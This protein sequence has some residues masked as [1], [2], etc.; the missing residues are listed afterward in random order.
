[1][2]AVEDAPARGAGLRGHLLPFPL[3]VRPSVGASLCRHLPLPVALAVGPD[4]QQA[5]PRTRGAQ[6]AQC[7]VPRAG[8][9]HL[10]SDAA[11]HLSAWGAAAGTCCYARPRVCPPSAR[12]FVFQGAVMDFGAKDDVLGSGD[13]GEDVD[14]QALAQVWMQ[15]LAAAPA[16]AEP[17]AIHI[18]TE[19]Q[20]GLLKYY[21]DAVL[22]VSGKD[23]PG[24]G[25]VAGHGD[26]AV[27]PDALPD[28][29]HD[30]KDNAGNGGG[31]LPADDVPLHMA[32]QYEQ[33][34]A[35]D[36][37]VLL[38]R[39]RRPAQG[40]LLRHLMLNQ[41]LSDLGIAS[42]ASVEL[43]SLHVTR[44]ASVRRGEALVVLHGFKAIIVWASKGGGDLC[45]FCSCG[46][47]RRSTCV[48]TLVK[49]RR[50]STCPHAAALRCAFSDLAL[51]LSLSSLGQLVERFPGLL[52]MASADDENPAVEHVTALRNDRAVWSV[53]AMGVWCTL[54]QPIKSASSQV[55]RCQNV[56]CSSRMRCVHVLAYMQHKADNVRPEDEDEGQYDADGV[57]LER[58]AAGTE[59]GGLPPVEV[60]EEQSTS[61]RSRNMLPCRG[62]V[63]SCTIFDSYGRAGRDSLS[64]MGSLPGV[65][66]ERSCVKCS[67]LRENRPLT[68]TE[69]VLFTMGGRVAVR[70]GVWTCSCTQVVRYDGADSSL[71]AFSSKT[72][73][74]RMYLD[75]VLHIALTSRSSFTAA[76]AA[77]AF[78]LHVTAGLPLAVFGQTR[79]IIIQA[80]GAYTETLIIPP[81]TYSCPRCL[82]KSGER[83]YVTMIADGQV[84]GFFREMARP[85]VRHLIDNPVVD[86]LI[87]NGCSVKTA[88]V[89]SAI[90][91]RC[92]TP[93]GKA[94]S[95]NAAEVKALN[96][97]L[98]L[99]SRVPGSERKCDDTEI[100]QSSAAEAAWAASYI[101]SSFFKIKNI[102][103][104]NA[105]S[106]DSELSDDVQA[107]M[108]SSSPVD[109]NTAVSSGAGS[110]SSDQ[111]PAPTKS[112]TAQPS[113]TAT[114][115]H[116]V[117]IKGAAGSENCNKL[118]VLERWRVVQRFVSTF[119]AK[120]VIGIFAGSDKAGIQALV[121][122]LIDGVKQREWQEMTAPVECVSLVWPFLYQVAE[123]LD[124]DPDL[125]RAIGE[126][127]LFAVDS[128]RRMEVLWLEK[129]SPSQK[130]FAEKWATTDRLKYQTWEREVG[131]IPPAPR[132]LAH[133][134]SLRRAV[135]QE[136][137][138]LSGSIFPALEPVRPF[139]FDLVAARKRSKKATQ[140]RQKQRRRKSGG[141][142]M[143][144]V[145]GSVKKA[146]TKD[147]RGVKTKREAGEQAKGTND[148]DCR[149]AFAESNVF[150]PGMVNFVCPDGLLVG[151]EMLSSAE[152]P[153]CI[154]E[155]LA[156]RLP[157][158]PSV[159]Y[160]D[161]A[162]Q[163][164]RNTTR[165]MPWLLRLSLVMWFLDRFHQPKHVCSDMFNPDAFPGITSLH[166]TSVAESR[167]ALNKPLRNQV[168]YMTQDRFIAHM[169]L[170]GALN[171]LRV[172]QK[173][174]LQPD[175]D[176]TRP[177]VGHR[178][179]PQ[180]FHQNIVAHCERRGCLCGRGQAAAGVLAGARDM[181][182]GDA[183]AAEEERAGDAA[184]TARAASADGAADPA[185]AGCAAGAFRASSAASAAHELCGAPDGMHDDIPAEDEAPP[186]RG[187]DVAARTTG[188]TFDA[189]GRQPFDEGDDEAAVT[190]ACVI[191]ATDRDVRGAGRSSVATAAQPAGLPPASGPVES[192]GNRSQ[193]ALG[194][195]VGDATSRQ[196][197]G[198]SDDND[199]IKC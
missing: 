7:W 9:S 99:G 198:H 114:A 5:P 128:E 75:I 135:A 35:Q 131:V 189:T 129:A 132:V 62:E 195:V 13:G 123:D 77:M 48:E 32:R 147:K 55:P 104:L 175:D 61:R 94:S 74:T 42:L 98:L 139:T 2:L 53:R 163:A 85:Y 26:G 172:L 157:V 156:R 87:S 96:T 106:S 148:D 58:P 90:R 150:T 20:E 199:N 56:L 186:G 176:K 91:K 167:H 133:P 10:V 125:A 159:I 168:S 152:S 192:L 3:S 4:R 66:H 44:V 120:P 174:H 142:A 68:T 37:Q 183:R 166:K 18:P 140:K 30:N 178:P 164:A 155:I 86:V 151:F 38:P 71:F 115:W 76:T 138:R 39:I 112:A 60:H 184:I 70:T 197:E 187:A 191:S 24:H 11:D 47:E 1:M 49:R 81:S 146:V 97:F 143:A 154:A 82:S 45:F 46:G 50:S 137:E 144:E 161:T 43:G 89:R 108:S 31:F 141:L 64:G 28:G 119:L 92:S 27:G 73:F 6:G 59:A 173:M 124:G 118:L 165:R 105:D 12:G 36:D 158:L 193:G 182:R 188:D 15:G 80:T 67:R 65:L 179:L 103:E 93:C 110:S 88:S 57:L 21:Q 100:G 162:C 116:C 69:A 194:P 16:G 190:K 54:V 185:G 149:H 79:Q 153:A 78:C 23:H 63:R 52:G 127:L 101:F 41:L 122:A 177:E 181:P 8:S 117:R 25:D 22:H 121:V 170:Y 107:E 136:E 102:G 111:E 113:R 33:P 14:A 19:V 160:F 95:L 34:E 17:A 109:G 72:V 169:R 126:L 134:L 196:E 130:A 180:F 40:V 171:N 84:L 145:G 83:Q 29:E 51:Q